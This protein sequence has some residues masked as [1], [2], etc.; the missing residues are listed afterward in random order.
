MM[1][2]VGP[3]SVKPCV[4]SVA[5]FATLNTTASPCLS[6]FASIAGDT[7]IE[8]LRSATS[9]VFD[10]GVVM[11]VPPQSFDI[12]IDVGSVVMLSATDAYAKV[13]SSE[14]NLSHERRKSPDDA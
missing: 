5:R 11:A 4:V 1:L 2:P 14:A 10:V 6:V 3:T 12:A 8:K 7:R 13:G 9:N